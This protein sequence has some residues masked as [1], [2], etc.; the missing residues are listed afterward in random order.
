MNHNNVFQNLVFSLNLK[1]VSVIFQKKLILRFVVSNDLRSSTLLSW[2]LND[3]AKKEIQTT[4]RAL[5]CRTVTLK[6]D[7]KKDVANK[8]CS[9]KESN[10]QQ[11]RIR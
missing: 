11:G 1:K 3:E 10:F 4:P 8:R 9:K 6:A 2:N 7:P 5:I